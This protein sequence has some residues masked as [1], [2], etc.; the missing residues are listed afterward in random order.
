MSFQCNAA[1]KEIPLDLGQAYG[2]YT[3]FRKEG[4]SDPHYSIHDQNLTEVLSSVSLKKIKEF[5]NQIASGEPQKVMRYVNSP[6]RL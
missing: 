6:F 3:A 1:P 5:Q 2:T 4:R